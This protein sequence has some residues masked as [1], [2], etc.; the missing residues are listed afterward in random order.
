MSYLS[1]IIW[2]ATWP[3]FI[4]VSYKTALWALKKLDKEDKTE[5]K[6]EIKE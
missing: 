5:N 1:S 3:I 2:L 4:Y 6:A